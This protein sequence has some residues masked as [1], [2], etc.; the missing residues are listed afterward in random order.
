MAT[1]CSVWIEF[2]QKGQKTSF[3]CKADSFSLIK[4]HHHLIN[5]KILKYGWVMSQHSQRM[6]KK[7]RQTYI[8]IH[9]ICT[10]YKMRVHNKATKVKFSLCLDSLPILFVKRVQTS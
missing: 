9:D 1:Q 3:Y 4:R 8:S 6:T 7:P 5:R 10:F 2:C